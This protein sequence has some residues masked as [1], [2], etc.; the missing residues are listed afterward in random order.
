MLLIGVSACLFHPDPSRATFGPKTL[1]YVESDMARYLT[2]EDVTPVLIPDLPDA[3]IR[4]L[5][6]HLHGLV[7]QGGVD[8]AP[9]TYGETPILDGRWKG[10]PIRD[11]YELEVMRAF[12]D[13][14]RPVLGICRGFQLMNAYFGGTLYQDIATQRP[15]S[16][17]HRDA[18]EYDRV[19][20]GISWVEGS[21]MQQL[22]RDET[23]DKVNSV[24]HQGVKDLG[25]GLVV[26]GHCKEDGIIEAFIHAG[27][28]PGKV[29]GVQWHPE[30]SHALGDTVISP[31]PLINTFLGFA[32]RQAR[33]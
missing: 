28:E 13:E 22:H 23:S 2:R 3:D 7:L 25:K 8:L 33:P 29:M 5:A 20:H 4:R 18:V 27:H 11:G 10:D 26:Q 19:H 15:E 14:G 24:H 30:Y 6:K 16:V 9:Q 17:R 32:K 21:F 12:M 31:E 1:C